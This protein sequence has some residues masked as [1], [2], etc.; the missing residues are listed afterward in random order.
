VIECAGRSVDVVV[1]LPGNRE[2]DFDWRVWRVIRHVE[3][4]ISRDVIVIGEGI[5]LVLGEKGHWATEVSLDSFIP[6]VKLVF[7]FR[8]CGHKLGK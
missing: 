7:F 2:A 6:I 4:Q 3:R 1:P 8:V 5:L